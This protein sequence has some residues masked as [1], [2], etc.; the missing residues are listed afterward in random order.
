[1]NGARRS[2]GRLAMLPVCAWLAVGFSVP[3]KVDIDWLSL[4]RE[5]VSELE[6]APV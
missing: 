4:R 1:M 5:L 3:T 6:Q 2:L